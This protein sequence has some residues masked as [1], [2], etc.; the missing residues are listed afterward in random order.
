MVSWS[1][2]L[3]NVLVSDVLTVHLE[4]KIAAH[5]ASLMVM[6]TVLSSE[7]V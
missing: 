2:L 7:M 5:V 4:N 6:F 3:S 1:V